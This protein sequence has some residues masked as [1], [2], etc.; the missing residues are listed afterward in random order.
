MTF[1]MHPVFGALLRTWWH[2]KVRAPSVCIHI[3]PEKQQEMK[4]L[5]ISMASMLFLFKSGKRKE[6]CLFNLFIKT[7]LS[8]TNWLHQWK[9][10]T[11]LYGNLI[12]I[13][14]CGYIRPFLKVPLGEITWIGLALSSDNFHYCC[15]TAINC[16][17]CPPFWSFPLYFYPS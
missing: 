11:S 16:P 10:I 15:Y 7:Y 8:L 1:R 14:R 4:L 3:S 17:N 9:I 5:F 13:I 12:I 6:L 2:F